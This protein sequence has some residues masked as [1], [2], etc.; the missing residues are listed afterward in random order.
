VQ[1]DRGV[2]NRNGIN[3]NG[4]KKL[5]ERRETEIV[6]NLRL[7]ESAQNHRAVCFLKTY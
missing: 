1:A 4:H 7:Y 2:N 6:K 5:G 3:D